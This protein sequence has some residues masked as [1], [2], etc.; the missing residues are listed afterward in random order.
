MAE[1]F[2]KVATPESQFKQS[3]GP[4]GPSVDVNARAEL[5][6]QQ[7]RGVGEALMSLVDTGAKVVGA[8]QEYNKAELARMRSENQLD[9]DA[10]LADLGS[11]MSTYIDEQ[12]EGKSL[13]DY[14]PEELKNHV[15]GAA[16]AFVDS[17]GLENKGYYKLIHEDL[18]NKSTVFFNRQTKANQLVQQERRYSTLGESFKSILAVSE[19]PTQAVDAFN[20]KLDE[21][22]GLEPRLIEVDGEQ[23]M[24]NPA[25]KDTRENAKLRMLQPML[26]KMMEERSPEF[27]DMMASE[28]FKEFFD[29]PDYDNVLE[30]AKQ[31]VQSTI[32]KRRQL[33]FDRIEESGY[34]MID[35]GA[36]TRPQDVEG[37]FKQ[38]VDNMSERDRPDTKQLMQL[39]AK[40]KKAVAVESTFQTLYPQIKKGD[41][42]VLDRSGLEKKEVE[43]MKNKFFTVETGIQDLSPQGISEAVRSGNHDEELKKYFSSGYAMPPHLEKWAN[44]PPSKGI[45]GMRD[46]YETF[47]Q[48][49][50]ITQDTSRTTMDLFNPKEYG[51]MMFAGN[52]IDNIDSGVMD[53][54]EA[55]QIYSTFNNDLQKNVDSFGTYTS[56]KAHAALQDEGV[57]E[58]LA[59]MKTD[60]PWT[61]DDFS[62]QAYMGRQFKNYF[63]YAMET[64]D[65]IEEAKKTAEKMFYS[66]HTAFENPDGSEGVMTHEFKGFEV[67]DFVSVA[68]NLLEFRDIKAAAGYL[69]LAKDYDFKGN[70][71][72]RPDPSYEKNKLM[73]FYYDDKF[74]VSMSADL[75]KSNVDKINK[76]KISSA[77]ERNVL[78]TQ[79]NK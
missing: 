33:N 22:V 61:Y 39:E 64:T 48:L 65:D 19:D 1:F 7:R 8:V 55:L 2:K 25:I 13:T 66:R 5:E 58:W 3:A 44:T 40:M 34:A 42:T 18:K 20:A 62:S 78:K 59:D 75:M 9:V 6:N 76:S 31:Q 10:D 12:E 14:E 73:N 51:R 37:F 30:G 63:S 11:F 50:S 4:S 32:N 56:P 57:K 52:L 53:D 15:D 69:G 38:H 60:A 77:E 49:N 17:K 36:V 45:E 24:V 41:Y 72:F 54:K 71:A 23:V 70:L 21:S 28:D 27:L 35:M 47:L 74:I 46:K 43:A 68:D 26:E 67:K 29:I 16:K 79:T